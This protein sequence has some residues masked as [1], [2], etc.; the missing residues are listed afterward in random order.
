[1]IVLLLH[2]GNDARFTEQKKET[3]NVKLSLFLFCII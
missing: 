2:F 3:T 1:M